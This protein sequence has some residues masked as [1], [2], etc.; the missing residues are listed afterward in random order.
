MYENRINN[1]CKNENVHFEDI[2]TKSRFTQGGKKR[3]D[4]WIKQD[5]QKIRMKP[6]NGTSLLEFFQCQMYLNGNLNI[7]VLFFSVW[8]T[9]TSAT[10]STR[11]FAGWSTSTRPTCC[12]AI[13]SLRICS[14]TRHAISRSAISDWPES[15]IQV[16]R[17]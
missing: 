14:W 7:L 17:K 2:T 4:D 16:I 12:T 1:Y 9:T 8:A 6:K 5:P 15:P 11:S 13:S 3:R 10:F